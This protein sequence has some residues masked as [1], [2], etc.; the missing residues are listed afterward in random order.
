MVYFT[1][2]SLGHPARAAEKSLAGVNPR[3][4]CLSY[5]F[6]N[7]IVPAH[8][9]CM[10]HSSSVTVIQDGTMCAS[11]LPPQN[12][13]VIETLHCR[14]NDSPGYP[15]A[16]GQLDPKFP[17]ILDNSHTPRGTYLLGAGEG[18]LVDIKNRNPDMIPIS[19][20]LHD[21]RYLSHD[22]FGDAITARKFRKFAG[23]CCQ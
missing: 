9:F 6:V 11:S 1:H 22:T 3:K 8:I 10:G 20:Y 7:R 2:H 23:T 5:R 17:G 16:R 18:G 13:V 12:S 4:Q 21:V 15:G 14:K 19:F